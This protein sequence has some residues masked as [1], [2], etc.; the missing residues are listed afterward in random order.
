M[1]KMVAEEREMAEKYRALAE[2]AIRIDHDRY[3]GMAEWWTNRAAEIEA[4]I[5]AQTVSLSKRRS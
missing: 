5:L 4:A 2:N 1:Q 3:S